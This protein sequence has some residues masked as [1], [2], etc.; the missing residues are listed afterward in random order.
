MKRSLSDIIRRS[1]R[2]KGPISFR[3]FMEMALYYPELGYYTS[4]RD[5]I[6]IRGDYY[7]S[8]HLTNI[9][10]CLIAKQLEEMWELLDKKEFTV[11]EYGAGMGLLCLDILKEIKKNKEFYDKLKYCIIEKSEAMRQKEREAISNEPVGAE[12]VT[13]YDSIK[14]IETFNGCVLANEVL[15][16]FSVHKVVM[17]EE[18][19]MEVFVDYQKDF[20]EVL[21]PANQTLKNYF[22]NLNVTLPPGFQTEVNLQA[23]DW[24]KDISGSL[25]KGFV[26]TVDYGFPSSELY[27]SYRRL[28]TMVCYNKHAV[29]DLPYSDIGEQDITAHVNF[30]AL[31]FWGAKFGLMNCGFTKQTYFLTG[32]GLTE[33]LRKTELEADNNN[34]LKERVALLQTLLLSIGKRLK[35]FIQQKGLDQPVLSGLNFCQPLT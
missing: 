13:W 17:K 23:I 27:R 31:N 3:D 16:N 28:G 19:L 26:L 21:K 11:V 4:A 5:K 24:L 34:L 30:S 2:D 10:G 6:G 15:D 20:I 22:A 1:I 12:K 9:Y 32:L 8:P 25:K 18:G 7:T 14:D 33:L 29:N 35:V